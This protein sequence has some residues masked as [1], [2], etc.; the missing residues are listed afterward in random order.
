MQTPA[1]NH[2][3]DRLRE[4]LADYR[5]AGD[6]PAILNIGA[7][8]SS[9]IEQRLLDSGCRFV[10]DRIDVEDCTVDHPRVRDC[11]QCTVEEMTPLGSN[12]YVCAFANYVFEHVPDLSRAAAEIHRVLVPGGILVTTV[13]NLKAPEFVIARHAPARF[14]AA[15]TGGRGFHTCYSWSTTTELIGL[16]EA[17]GFALMET[18]YWAFTEGYLWRYPVVRPLSRLYDRL[19]SRTGA[20]GLMGNVCLTLK[21]P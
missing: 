2:L 14:Q 13:P 21:K 6:L 1:E 17:R 8:R 9:M 5:D 16:F 10:C 4:Y 20:K 18:R 15:M 12:Q 11:R 7:G 3:I 19:V